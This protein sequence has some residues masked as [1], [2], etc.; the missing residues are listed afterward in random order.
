MT[1]VELNVTVLLGHAADAPGRPQLDA[2]TFGHGTLQ[3]QFDD[4]LTLS[5]R[6]CWRPTRGETYLQRLL[7]AAVSGAT[8]SMRPTSLSEKPSS[9]SRNAWRRRTSTSSAEPFA[10]SHVLPLGD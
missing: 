3:E 9:S 4:L 5:T 8:L 6:Q 10:A 1:A 2:E 7:P